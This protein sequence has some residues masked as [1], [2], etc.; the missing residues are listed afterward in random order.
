[1]HPTQKPI[2]LAERAIKNSCPPNGYVY[3]PFLGSA[4]TLLAC[5]NLNRQ[6]RGIE[7]EPKYIAVT[8]ER[9]HQ[10]TGK[11]PELING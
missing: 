4:S 2:E 11:M 8:L 1:M 9:W 10:M 3:D 6:C 7:I 5:E